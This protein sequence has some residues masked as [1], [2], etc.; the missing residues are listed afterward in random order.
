M[1]LGDMAASIDDPGRRGHPAGVM[2]R[3]VAH[4]F[5]SAETSDNFAPSIMS[6][7]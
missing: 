6:V 5:D 2:Q 3:T 7:A 4:G 1:T